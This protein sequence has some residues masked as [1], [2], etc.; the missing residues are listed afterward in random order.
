MH[1]KRRIF[2]TLLKKKEMF[3][4]DVSLHQDLLHDKAHLFRADV[5]E[6]HSETNRFVLLICEPRG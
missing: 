4:I 1:E 5:A 3:V 2:S 6:G